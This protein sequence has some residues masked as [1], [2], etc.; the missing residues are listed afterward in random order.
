MDG[1]GGHAEGCTRWDGVLF[2]LEGLVRGDSAGARGYAEGETVGFGDDGAEV[3]ELLE[4]GPG[5][6]GRDG[7]ELGA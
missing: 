7:F 5:C 1:E 3:G 4:F 6:G 2:V